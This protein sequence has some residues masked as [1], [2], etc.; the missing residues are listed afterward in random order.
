MDR[1]VFLDRDGTMIH[2]PGYLGDPAAVQLLPGVVP[3]LSRF[4]AAGFGLVVISNQ[5]G[6]GRG[7]IS[8]DQLE[9]VHRRLEEVLLAE[10]LVLSGAWYCTHRPEAGCDCRKPRPGLLL[11]AARCLGLS[12]GDCWMIGDRPSDADAGRS[13]GCRALCLDA[14]TPDLLSAADL[15]LAEPRGADERR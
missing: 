8:I 9:A 6:V 14:K 15:V 13:A 4:T 7:L 11:R 1:V 5:S 10:G 3:G 2:D 12:L